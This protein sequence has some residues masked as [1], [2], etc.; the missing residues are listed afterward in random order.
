MVPTKFNSF[1]VDEE[2]DRVFVE[3]KLKNDK[4]TKK[5]LCNL[6]KVIIIFNIRYQL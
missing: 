3:E 4:L 5:F 1:A 6:N 2:K